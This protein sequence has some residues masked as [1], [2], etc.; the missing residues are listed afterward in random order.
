MTR[1]QL[2]YVLP[3]YDPATPT[4]FAH[5]YDL[6]QALAESVDIHLIVERG[7]APAGPFASVTVLKS[8]TF[9]GRLYEEYGEMAKLRQ[10]GCERFYVHYSFSGAIAAGVV[11]RSYGGAAYYWNCGMPW[12]Y[13]G[14]LAWGNVGAWLR[15]R[16]PLQLA[17]RL[18]THVVTGTAG[19]ARE[20]GRE[21]GLASG[22]FRILPNWIS[23][24]RF[25]SRTPASEVRARYGLAPDVPLVT[26]VHRLSPRKGADLIVP[27]A[28]KLATAGCVVAVAGHGPYERTLRRAVADA[29][30]A[31]RV[32][33]LGAVPNADVPD[34][35]AA[36]D[37]FL[38]PSEE[39]GFPRVLLEAMACGVPF[40]AADVGGVAEVV[41]P[42]S[43]L[44]TAGNVAGFAA[45]VD[46]L[47]ADPSLRAERAAAGA[48][49]VQRYD[50]PAVTSRFLELVTS[51]IH[52]R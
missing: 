16:M 38:M 17:L 37:V 2:A 41:P 10:A 5:L 11:A 6:L 9:L 44:V 31:S 26:F 4:H 49:W 27:I 43:A 32:L 42:G 22:K 34:L 30:L 18:C 47:L 24:A 40:V 25:A 33:L 50:L 14:P 48:A 15:R 19:M 35:L 36:S 51:P 20:Y 45:A 1:I 7:G 46:A 28:Q 52:P 8:Q 3:E 29:G 12:L 21:Y 39:E 23:L 13:T